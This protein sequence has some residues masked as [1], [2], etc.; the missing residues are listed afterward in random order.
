M[1]T[2]PPDRQ[3]IR[4]RR[5]WKFSVSTSVTL[6]DATGSPDPCKGAEPFVRYWPRVN[7]DDGR[8]ARCGSRANGI[9]IRRCGCCTQALQSIVSL[10][11]PWSVWQLGS[12][13]RR[14][15]CG[16][17]TDGICCGATS[18]TT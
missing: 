13:G 7:L 11:Q 17:V 15:R 14:D 3:L 5:V 4:Y 16:S 1:T 12:V 18:R 6:H 10:Q 9:P 8:L 2:L